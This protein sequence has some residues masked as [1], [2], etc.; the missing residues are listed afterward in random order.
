MQLRNF[1]GAS[2]FLLL[3]SGCSWFGWL[4]WVGD[5]E[6][7]GESKDEPAELTSIEA[8]VDVE[9]VWSAS[10]GDGLGKK[11]LELSPAVL[12]D[13]VFAADAYG[14]VE[15]RDRFDGKRLWRVHVGAPEADSFFDFTS[16]RDPSFVM[17]GVGAGEGLVLLGTARAEVIALSA[18]D[19]TELWRTKVSSEV[20]SPPVASGDLVF[21]QT[22]DGRLL[23]LDRETGAQRWSFD[24]QV[25]I[26]TL[27]GSAT[28]VVDGAMVYA[29]FATGKVHAFRAATG[30]PVWEQRVMLPQGRSELDRI[31]DV[32]GTPIISGPVLYAASYQ[33]RLKA[34]RVADGNE[35]WERD[36]SSYLD[37]AAGYGQVYVVDDH[38]VIHAID[39]STAEVVWEQRALYRRG[40]SSPVVFSSYLI[41]TD[42]EGY[43]HVLAQSD[44]RLV[45]RRK[46]DGDGVRSRTAAADEML[47][48]LGNGGKLVAYRIEPRG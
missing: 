43:L 32:D 25:P 29:G 24:T 31:V 26:L 11:Y 5:G 46:V 36:V 33:G 35:L 37:L 48:C 16:R 20:V 28:P 30:E 47:Y 41:V 34:L 8:E 10:I 19:G 15:A 13:R 12:A 4:P 18:V 2:C 9:R 44:G 27:R 17:G 45:G 23:A 1:V 6:E 39:Q 7:D 38:D 3:I 40:L 42:A 14:L 21:A 22:T